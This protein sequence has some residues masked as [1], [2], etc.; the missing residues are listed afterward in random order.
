MSLHLYSHGKYDSI[1]HVDS[2]LALGC[3]LPE[4]SRARFGDSDEKPKLEPLEQVKQQQRVYEKP[5]PCSAFRSSG[6][7]GNRRFR[8][9]YG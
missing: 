7:R 6:G 5:K 3:R 8:I 9:E 1:Q 4:G 2:G